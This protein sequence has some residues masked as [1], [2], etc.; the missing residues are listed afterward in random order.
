[1]I[2]GA[3]GSRWP[4]LERTLA[5]LLFEDPGATELAVDFRSLTADSS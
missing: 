4:A 1:M 2:S 5:A 3:A